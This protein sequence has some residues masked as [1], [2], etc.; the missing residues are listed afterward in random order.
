MIEVKTGEWGG[1]WG[2]ELGQDG[3]IALLCK[4]IS[5][6]HCVCVC[7]C[8]YVCACVYVCPS[9]PETLSRSTAAAV[10]CELSVSTEVLKITMVLC[11]S[12]THL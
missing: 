6:L 2:G 12:N 7:V 1:A 5:G 4:Q 8:V 9:I 3:G 10:C 11:H